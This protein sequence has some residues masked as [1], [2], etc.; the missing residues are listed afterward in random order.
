MNSSICFFQPSEVLKEFVQYYYM[1]ELSN[2]FG[3]AEFIQKQIPNGCVELFIGYQNTQSPFFNNAGDAIY[4]TSAIVGNHLLQNKIKGI[5][6]N[7]QQ[8]TIKFVAVNFKA[9]GFYEIFKIPS[10]EVYNDFFETS[11]VLGKDIKLLQDQLDFSKEN[12]MRKQCLDHFLISQLNKNS[13]KRYSLKAGFEIADFIRTRK[14]VIRVNQLMDKFK[15]S[16]RSLERNIKSA[17][18]LSLK[19]YCKISRFNGLFEFVNREVDVNWSDMVTH[20]GYYDQAHLINEFKIATGYPPAYFVKHR[21]KI[22]FK[23]GNH[24]ICLKNE[25]NCANSQKVITEG[26]YSYH[27]LLAA[28]IEQFHSF[29]SNNYI[30]SDFL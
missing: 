16:E 21:R 24:L 29:T 4:T 20:F 12:A 19:E 11:V 7:P 22:L 3:T 13:L 9:R 15:I 2:S 25:K 14:G 26:E 17:L 6:V 18:G 1:I 10:S 28:E 8:N 30:P 5:T 27:Q 23:M